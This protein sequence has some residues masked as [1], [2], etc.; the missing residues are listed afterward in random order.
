MIGESDRLAAFRR[1]DVD[2]TNVGTSMIRLVSDPLTI[3]T[4][5]GRHFPPRRLRESRRFTTRRRDRPDVV[6]TRR[7]R[8][9]GDQ[10]AIGRDVELLDP[11][12][13]G[14]RFDGQS[15]ANLGQGFTGPL[16]DRDQKHEQHY[17]DHSES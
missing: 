16:I 8:F 10:I 5:G 14:Q 3:G 9:E 7:S 1:H 17:A 12:G 11:D 15:V 6:G 4:E 13:L 2:V